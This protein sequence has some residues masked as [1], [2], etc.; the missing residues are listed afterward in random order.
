VPEYRG[1]PGSV[2]YCNVNKHFFVYLSVFKK[3]RTPR[4]QPLVL[5]KDPVIQ[6][7]RGVIENLREREN[8]AGKTGLPMIPI[9]PISENFFPGKEPCLSGPYPENR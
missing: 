2:I 7:C 6:H 8:L 5:F 3:R 9:S 1:Y 4:D